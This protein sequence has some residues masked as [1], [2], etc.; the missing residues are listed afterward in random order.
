MSINNWLY[1]AQYTD[2]LL[3][4]GGNGALDRYRT[5]LFFDPVPERFNRQ[6]EVVPNLTD[7]VH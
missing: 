5:A 3:T 2:W 7:H 4:W 6:A 1:E